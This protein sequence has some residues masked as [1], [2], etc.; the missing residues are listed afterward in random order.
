MDLKNNFEIYLRDILNH[1]FLHYHPYLLDDEIIEDDAKSRAHKYSNIPNSLIEYMDQ[2][3]CMCYIG[4]I[5]KQENPY[6]SDGEVV[7]YKTLPIYFAREN[8]SEVKFHLNKSDFNPRRYLTVCGAFTISSGLFGKES[9]DKLVSNTDKFIKTASTVDGQAEIEKYQD[10]C[11]V[12]AYTIPAFSGFGSFRTVYRLYLTEGQT[13]KTIREQILRTQQY[14]LSNIIHLPNL[15]V[16]KDIEFNEEIYQRYLPEFK[17]M[18]NLLCV[19]I[20]ER[21]IEVSVGDEYLPD[22]LDST[23][24]YF[25][26]KDSRPFY[27]EILEETDDYILEEYEGLFAVMRYSDGNDELRDRNN[28]RFRPRFRNSNKFIEDTFKDGQCY[29]RQILDEDLILC[30]ATDISPYEDEIYDD[31][32][33]NLPFWLQMDD[34][35]IGEYYY[36]DESE[37]AL[38]VN[39]YYLGLINKYGQTVFELNSLSSFK[40]DG[41]KD[42]FQFSKYDESYVIIYLSDSYDP[43]KGCYTKC[44][45]IDTRKGSVIIPLIFSYEEIKKELS[46]EWAF[47][48]KRYYRPGWVNYFNPHYDHYKVYTGPI[49]NSGSD[50][51]EQGKYAGYTI[52]DALYFHGNEILD[53]LI[54]KEKIFIGDKA[55][56]Q[57]VAHFTPVERSIKNL[58]DINLH[59]NQIV[60]VDDVIST[61]T[62]MHDLNY[63]VLFCSLYEGKTIR[64]IVSSCRGA[65]YLRA[66]V[67][68]HVLKINESVID[69]L[70]DEDPKIYARLAESVSEA[71]HDEWMRGFDD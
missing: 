1:P 56:P 26:K 34:Y 58:Q 67:S 5:S 22:I 35:G 29:F 19:E 53:D 6:T 15:I 9:C 60:D 51:L 13:A 33:E 63:S 49:Y 37:E 41:Y 48:D 70:L 3:C 21:G 55:L 12:L 39:H 20:K 64:E 42:K 4:K 16:P 68:N 7:E 32:P 18:Y 59:F 52:K 25:T 10:C 31:D 54:I 28:K 61:F 71:N 69:Q 65:F 62:A 30:L 36:Y 2:C 24:E 44:G 50:L 11:A 14:I 38:P 43:D 23:N 46:C 57:N 45:A 47:E 66:M 8:Y 27:T 17:Q 40:L